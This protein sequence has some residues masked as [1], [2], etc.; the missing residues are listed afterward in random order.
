MIITILIILVSL[1]G[2]LVLHELGH[3]I[4][5]KKLGVKVK[6]FG[7]GYPPRLFGK[8]IGETIYSINLLPFGAFVKIQGE[9]KRVKGSQSFSERPVWQ[10]VLIILGGAVSFWLVSFLIFSFVSGVW[11]LPLAVSDEFQGE[12]FVQII[13]VAKNSPAES[14]KIKS[15]DIIVK[16]KNQKS[17]IKNTNQKPKIENVNKVKEVQ[18]FIDSHK[19]EEITLTLERGKEVFDVNLVPRVLPPEGEGAI[20]VG[21]VRV[22]KIRVPWYQAPIQGMLVT[23]EKTWQIPLVFGSFFQRFLKGEKVEGVELVGPIGIGG[24]MGQALKLGTDN[25]LMFV[26]MISLWLALFNLLPIPALDGGKLL[27]LG[28]EAVRRKPVP[29]V[30]EEKITTFFFLFLI[31]LMVFVTIKDIT[32][33][34]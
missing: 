12:V 29:Q 6:E 19:G 5:A 10:R 14:A 7:L 2:L 24:L 31:L 34:F 26:A 4:L 32:R 21:L 28:I 15:G 30:I 8:K 25:F 22:A 1:I 13:Q 20:G 17:K 9:E 27:F 23:A 18:D 16:I 11:G 3:F 33:L